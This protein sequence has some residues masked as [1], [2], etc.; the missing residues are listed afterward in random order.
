LWL[1]GVRG[2]CVL[3]WVRFGRKRVLD[4]VRKGTRGAEQFEV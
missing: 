3:R 1:R 4:Y 2:L